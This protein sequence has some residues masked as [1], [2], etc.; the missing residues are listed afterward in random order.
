MN[1]CD[2]SATEARRLMASKKLSAV[3]L[4][5][6]CIARA[7]EVN[8]AV[9]ALVV[10]DF[11]KMRKAAAEAQ[12]AIDR[13]DKLGTLHGLPV[14]VKDMVDVEGLPTTFGSE[15]YADNIAKGD[16]PMI[17][18]LRQEGALMMGKA[19]NPE[20]SAGGNTRNAVYGVTANP[21]DLTRS[22]AGSSGGSA[23]ALA[24][25]M[26]P[27]ATGS[28]TGGS[29]R[30]P[31]SFCGVVGFRATP[32]VVPGHS[33]PLGWLPMSMNGPM[34][35]TVDDAALMLSAMI[36]P[37]RRDPW[38][39]VIEGQA[40]HNPEAFRH[41]PRYDLCNA[42]VAFTHN[43][44]FA[45]TEKLVADSFHAKLKRFGHV[46][47][48]LN[49]THPDCLN[50]DDTFA[51]IRALCFSG[52]HRDLAKQYPDK[53]GPNVHDNVIEGESYSA[54]D[55]VR[56]LTNQTKLYRQWQAFFEHHDFIVAPTTTISPRDWHEL[57]PTE[58]DGEPTQS[59]YHWLSMAYASTLAGHPSVTLP[60]GRDADGM[61]FGLQIIGRRGSDLETLAF[62]RELETLFKGDVEL[63]RP[64]VDLS[65]LK[66]ASPISEVEG[67]L[68]FA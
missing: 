63:E 34:A 35:R 50:A 11:A 17:Q 22:C 56:A 27:L 55:V 65:Y 47:G 66:N 42:R 38:T 20:W 51:V 19:N 54:L 31:A 18:Q 5:E 62:A 36:R 52:H 2:L 48:Q 40:A 29:L 39:P 43:F 26:S 41:L 59:Y 24:C 53:V 12:N 37:D 67:F 23:V 32:G 68:G 6:S 4:T 25:G 3:E 45:M 13:G 16:D 1:P 46:F 7:E 10:D 61:P 64:Q 21:Y 58:I 44:G 9:N 49:D 8:H 15:I 57:F 60:T 14:S 33:R 30:N 28:D